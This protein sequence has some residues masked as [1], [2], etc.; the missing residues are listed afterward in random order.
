MKQKE[1]GRITVTDERMT[2]FWLTLQQ[3]VEFVIN[4][5]ELM[6]GGEVFVPKIPSM[7][8]MDLAE[9]IAPECMIDIIGIRPGEKLHEVLI[10]QD[11]S[12]HALELENMYVILP[13]HP[14]WKVDYWKEGKSLQAGF[15]YS[16]DKN[17]DWLSIEQLL[18]I[19]GSPNE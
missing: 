9:A 11:E 13:A 12:R 15:S 2:R 8:V 5:I 3:G 1:S 19:I 16:S 10:S 6:K 4:S 18:K 7:R 17:Q 14:W